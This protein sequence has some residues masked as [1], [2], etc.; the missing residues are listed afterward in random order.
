M[1][2]RIQAEDL[3]G[4]CL[5]FQGVQTTVDEFGR[6]R[7]QGVDALLREQ[8]WVAGGFGELLDAGGDI[9]GVAD[10]SETPVCFRRR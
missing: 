2:H 3:Y 9:D 4:G 7:C 10:Q 1:V 5:T 6:S 8:D